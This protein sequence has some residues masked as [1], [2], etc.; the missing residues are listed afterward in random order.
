[1]SLNQYT[2]GRSRGGVTCWNISLV[3]S[4]KSTEIARIIDMD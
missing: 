2:Y 3:I 4:W 1:M